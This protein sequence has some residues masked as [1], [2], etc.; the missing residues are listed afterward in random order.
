MREDPVAGPWD[1]V[2]H[3][4]RMRAS[5][6]DRDRVVDALKHAYVQGLITR[7]ELGARAGRALAARYLNQA[8]VLEYTGALLR[9]YARLL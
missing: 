3:H 7:D 1:Q 5:D 9:A 6:A 2:A 8:S 4:G